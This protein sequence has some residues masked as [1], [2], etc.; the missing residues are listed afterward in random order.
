MLAL[1]SFFVGQFILGFLCLELGRNIQEET[2]RNAFFQKK[3]EEPNDIT[4]FKN[5]QNVPK[6]PTF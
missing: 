2:G 1:G 6:K 3:H 5:S 4:T